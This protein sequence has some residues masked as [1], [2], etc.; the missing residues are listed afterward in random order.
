[1]KRE[2]NKHVALENV[3]MLVLNEKL[4]DFIRRQGVKATEDKCR[5]VQVVLRHK[6]HHF[7]IDIPFIAAVKN[8]GEGQVAVFNIKRTKLALIPG[9]SIAAE[10]NVGKAFEISGVRYTLDDTVNRNER[11]KTK[12]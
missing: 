9:H 7:P 11:F 8:C 1:M 5:L 12:P 4:N 3:N 2:K 6:I 10:T